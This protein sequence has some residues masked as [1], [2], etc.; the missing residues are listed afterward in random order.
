MNCKAS[1]VYVSEKEEARIEHF[2][3]LATN[4][5]EYEAGSDEWA[6]LN[7]AA[8]LAYYNLTIQGQE[9]AYLDYYNQTGH[10]WR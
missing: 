2:L 7:M 8:R 3:N 1:T 10:N 6:R 9:I 4:R 5:N